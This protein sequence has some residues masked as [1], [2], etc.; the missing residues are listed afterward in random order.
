MSVAVFHVARV[1]ITKIRRTT[2]ADV[3]LSDGVTIPFGR[4]DPRR[5]KRSALKAMTGTN[6][7]PGAGFLPSG[8]SRVL[9]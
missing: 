1:Q 6:D 2:V 9:S 3:K 8:D 5:I 7:I 4:H